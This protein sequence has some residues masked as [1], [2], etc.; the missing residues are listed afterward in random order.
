MPMRR[1]LNVIILLLLSLLTHA[2]L[3]LDTELQEIHKAIYRLQLSR[4]ELDLA[5]YEREHPNQQTTAYLRFTSSFLKHFVD[6][7]VDA[8]ERDRETMEAFI[9]LVESSDRV[10]NP[11]YYLYLGEMNLE[12]A[13]MEI[14]FDHRWKALS[15]ALDGLSYFEEGAEK[16]PNFTPLLMG[17]GVLNVGLGSIPDN[18]QFFASV[19]GFSGDLEL[20]IRQLKKAA[21]QT[22]TGAYHYLH[23]KHVLCY[24]YIRHQLYPDEPISV[25]D[26]S[27]NPGDNPLLAYVE[28]HIQHKAGNV[29]EVISVLGQALAVKGAHVFP[30]LYYLYGRAKL[31]RM[32]ADADVPLQRYLQLNRGVYYRRSTLRYLSWFEMLHG[33]SSHSTNYRL[34]IATEGSTSKGADLDA[35][36]DANNH[37]QGWNRRL[38]QARLYFDAGDSEKALDILGPG[39][40]HFCS[41]QADILEYHYRKGRVL[42]SLGRDL[43]AI[44]SFEKAIEYTPSPMTHERVSAEMELA[45]LLEPI[46]KSQ[47]LTHYRAVLRYEGYPWYEGTQQRAKVAISR[48]SD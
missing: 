35:T 3:P 21:V 29:D 37:P 40:Q 2:Q 47:A 45:A 33:E 5:R 22:E 42:Q 7:D 19:L 28:A 38:V 9:D 15:Y 36:T 27:L 48:L 24:T 31:A 4:A 6:E 11:Y 30:Y 34:R 16:F 13:S 1:P 17:Q 8:Y 14:K 12:M 44:E 18:M 10:H 32:D 20:G 26:W 46:R 39:Y 43:E 25:R 41:S 23:E